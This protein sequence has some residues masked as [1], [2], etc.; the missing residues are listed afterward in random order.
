MPGLF[1]IC[2][3]RRRYLVC[4]CDGRNSQEES[5]LETTAQLFG[6]GCTWHSCIGYVPVYHSRY[7]PALSFIRGFG[8]AGRDSFDDE[9]ADE[10]IVPCLPVFVDQNPDETEVKDESRHP[11]TDEMAK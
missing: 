4:Q 11:F 5:K 2:R 3:T 6:L 7:S 1:V 8:I 9:G 10:F